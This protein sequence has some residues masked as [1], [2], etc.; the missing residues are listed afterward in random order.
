MYV[1]PRPKAE[2]DPYFATRL[3]FG[4]VAALVIAVLIQ[5]KMLV[6]IP[7]LTVGLMGGMRKAFDVKK[8]VGGPLALIVV[9][10]FFYWLMSLVHVMPVLALAIVFLVSVMA[11]LIVLKT[12]NPIGML[13]LIAITLMSVMGAKSLPAM[14]IIKES[15][16]EGALT[17]LIIIPILYW[18]LPTKAKTP[19]IEHYNPDTYGYHWQRAMIRSV[20][21]LLLLGWLYTVLDTSNMILAMAAVFSLVFPT[22]K[23]QFDEAKE[24]SFATVIGGVLALIILGLTDWMGHLSILLTLL[25]LVAFFLGDRMINGRHPPMVYQ[26]ALSVMLA[27]TLGAL[28]NQEP[29]SATMLRVSLTLVGAVGAAYL[30]ALL[31]IILLPQL[32]VDMSFSKNP[33]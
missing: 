14:V 13:I 32:K 5:S 28:T 22:R 27:L 6:L 23:H 30:S 1:A 10:T 7:A 33:E 3:A 15:F 17:A 20:V 18:V 31:E 24:R 4:C 11:Y 8:A 21:L 2:H 26:F 16:I 25:F 19:L 29:V 9:I 12:G